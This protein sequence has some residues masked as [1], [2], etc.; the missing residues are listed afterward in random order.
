MAEFRAVAEALPAGPSWTAALAG[1]DV[2][3]I[4]EVK[5]RSPSVGSIASDLD[6]REH[7]R[8]YELGGASAISV[9]TDARYF[10]GCLGDLSRVSETVTVPVLRKDFILDPIQVYESRATGA[11]AILLIVRA[12]DP[13][14]LHD[15]STLAGE[16][17]LGALLEVHDLKELDIALQV[18]AN[19]V[20]VNS[21][22]LATFQVDLTTLAGVLDQVPSH[23]VAVAESG[24]KNRADVEKVASWGADAVLVGTVLAGASDPCNAVR[25]LTGV[26]R[27]GRS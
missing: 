3:V 9:L 14:T 25:D 20:G 15:L 11:A 23:V 7:A 6:P 1:S 4:A 5:R 8:A 18:S 26:A 19:C 16:L 2:A 17:G 22:D 12:L 13:V 27:R 21:R 24:L 10:G